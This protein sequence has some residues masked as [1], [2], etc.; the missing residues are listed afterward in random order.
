LG[1]LVVF[2]ALVAISGFL[3]ADTEPK[4]LRAKRVRARLIA[5]AI[6]AIP[7]HYRRQLVCAVF[8]VLSFLG[9]ATD[10]AGQGTNNNGTNAS[11]TCASGVMGY[12]ALGIVFGPL[13]LG[14]HLDCC[15]KKF[16]SSTWATPS[17][18]P[19][20]SRKMR[21]RSRQ[22]GIAGGSSAISKIRLANE[23]ATLVVTHWTDVVE[24][25]RDLD[26]LRPAGTPTSPSGQTRPMASLPVST[27]Q[28]LLKCGAPDSSFRNPATASI[29]QPLQNE[30]PEPLTP[31]PFR[32]RHRPVRDGD[33]HP[34]SSRQVSG[35]SNPR[36][37][38]RG[39]R[40]FVR[41]QRQR[42]H[43]A[44]AM[45][46]SKRT[47]GSSALSPMVERSVDR[48]PRSAANLNSRQHGNSE[49]SAAAPISALA[50]DSDMPCPH[51]ARVY[52]TRLREHTGTPESLS[53]ADRVSLVS[54]IEHDAQKQPGSGTAISPNHVPVR[55][56]P[57]NPREAA[58]T[59]S[60]R[61]RRSSKETP[62]ASSTKRAPSGLHN[63]T[64]HHAS[65]PSQPHSYA[66]VD[67]S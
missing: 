46:G 37:Q 57:R 7:S 15:D 11:T 63:G 55:R 9:Q 50:P 45:S 17:T 30:S 62:R 33:I 19:R 32:R 61:R 14:R 40:I 44:C 60:S 24:Y 23:V 10:R 58:G 27:S 59:P 2:D 34:P 67:I 8:G 16:K 31:P 43:E 47:E 13:L 12:N 39:D 49:I 41:R 5:L 64:Y 35:S 29:S 6:G 65:P 56:S 48:L 36:H 21:R 42:P 53:R 52:Q 20:M 54:V 22:Y 1:S 26:L 66:A 38:D 51:P 25:L 3:P 28:P 18:S 4:E